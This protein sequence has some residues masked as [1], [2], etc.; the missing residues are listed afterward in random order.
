MELLPSEWDITDSRTLKENSE[1]NCRRAVPSLQGIQ[2]SENQANNLQVIECNC[3][4]DGSRL[5]MFIDCKIPIDNKT[6]SKINSN[7]KSIFIEF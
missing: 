6:I 1:S 4:S 2:Q 5:V 3:W 7:E